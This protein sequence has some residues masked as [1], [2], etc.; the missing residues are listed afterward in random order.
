MFSPIHWTDIERRIL[1]EARHAVRY[2][3]D[4]GLFCDE[5]LE[6]QFWR[7]VIYARAVQVE[8]GRYALERTRAVEHR[9]AEPGRMRARAVDADIAFVPVA[10]VE[11]PGLG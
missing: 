2:Q 9:G 4:P 7:R 10:F 5:R 11:G 3:T 8:V 6:E 1:V